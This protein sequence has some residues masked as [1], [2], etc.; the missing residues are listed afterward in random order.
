MEMDL[1]LAQCGSGQMLL[2][3]AVAQRAGTNSLIFLSFCKLLF[4][5]SWKNANL[6]VDFS[7]PTQSIGLLSY[8]F[9]VETGQTDVVVPVVCCVILFLFFAQDYAPLSLFL[10]ICFLFLGGLQMQSIKRTNYTTGA[11]WFRT[12]LL[13]FVSV[14]EMVP[15]CNR[16]RV[17]EECMIIHSMSRDTIFNL[18]QETIGC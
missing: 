12:L 17:I 13:K 5:L 10:M 14:V 3:S 15:F 6:L 1:R 2:F 9:L 16:R 7:G 8:T 4:F 18:L 11:T